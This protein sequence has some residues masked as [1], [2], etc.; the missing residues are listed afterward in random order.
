M[1]HIALTAVNIACCVACGMA[2][3]GYEKYAA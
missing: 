3:N 2:A 1:R